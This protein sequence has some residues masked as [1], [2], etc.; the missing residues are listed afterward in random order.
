MGITIR[1]TEWDRCDAASHEDEQ[2]TNSRN[3]KQ[4]ILHHILLKSVKIP[5]RSKTADEA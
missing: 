5:S 3:C 4:S 1:L 2:G